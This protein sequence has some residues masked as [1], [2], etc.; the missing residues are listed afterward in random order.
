MWTGG[1]Q[2]F[3]YSGSFFVANVNASVIK[4]ELNDL[5]NIYAI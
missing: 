4:A 2:L 5:F 1:V 3:R